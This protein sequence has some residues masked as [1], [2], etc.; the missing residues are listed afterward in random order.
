MIDKYHR[1]FLK[2][3]DSTEEAIQINFPVYSLES[4]LDPKELLVGDSV[5]HAASIVG[6]QRTGASLP[7][8][9]L[10]RE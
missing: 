4:C 1:E 8:D 5:Y 10:L 2:G 7:N 6:D 9:E 3:P